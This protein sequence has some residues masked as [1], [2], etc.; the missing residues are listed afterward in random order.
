M[1]VVG[2]ASVFIALERIGATDLLPAVFGEVHVPAAV[3]REVYES[4]RA[5]E[6]PAWVVRHDEPIPA[7]QAL[8]LPGLDAGEIAAIQLALSLRADL[9]LMDEAADRTAARQLG[10]PNTGLLGVL[11]AAKRRGIID[12]VAPQIERLRASGFWLSE[13]LVT[14]ILSDLGESR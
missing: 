13:A 1:I 8:P 5:T 2:D 12:R 3:W 10:I 14:Q 4:G 6:P 9:L 11:A 7:L